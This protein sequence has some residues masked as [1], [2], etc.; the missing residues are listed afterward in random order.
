MHSG[1]LALRG[2]VKPLVCLSLNKAIELHMKVFAL[3]IITMFPAVLM[4]LSLSSPCTNKWPKDTPAGKVQVKYRISEYC[5]PEDVKFIISEPSGEFNDFAMCH[6]KRVFP[7]WAP[8]EPMKT[9]TMKEYEKRIEEGRLSE[10]DK[11][12]HR[13]IHAVDSTG[14]QIILTCYFNKDWAVTSHAIRVGKTLKP[15]DSDYVKS[16][17]DQNFDSKFKSKL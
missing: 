12:H 4:A 11:Y 7:Y 17:P 14:N 15:V 13:T 3:F 10:P 6:I 9:I 16:L 1:L 8:S 5:E 2:T